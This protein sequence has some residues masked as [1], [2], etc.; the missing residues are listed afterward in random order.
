MFSDGGYLDRLT[1]RNCDVVNVSGLK[2][3]NFEVICYIII[4]NKYRLDTTGL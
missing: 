3:L 1:L 4:D 2:P